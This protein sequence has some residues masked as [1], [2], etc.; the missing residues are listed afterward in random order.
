MR[1]TTCWTSLMV[2]VVVVAGMASALRMVGGSIAIPAAAPA[3][4][5]AR[6]R[7]SRLLFI[8]FIR[9]PVTPGYFKQLQTFVKDATARP[10]LCG[11]RGGSQRSGLRLQGHFGA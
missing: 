5:A 6:R 11:R 7:K 3:E 4:V 8:G 9:T 1:M 10:Y 2:P